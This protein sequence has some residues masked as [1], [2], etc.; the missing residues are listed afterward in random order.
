VALLFGCTGPAENPVE[1][2]W[3]SFVTEAY[4]YLTHQQ[5]LAKQDF[6]LGSWERYFWD[7]DA[8]TLTFSSNG[9]A[10][11]VAD[12][13]IVGSI[14]E[15]SGTWLWSWANSSILESMSSSIR[16]V[17]SLGEERGFEKLTEANWPG[18]E[19]DG[20]EMT[21]VAA[22]LLSAKGAYRAPDEDGALFLI[23]TDIH[24]VE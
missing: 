16:R 5:D 2:E 4:Q 15:I 14:S 9:R 17:R 21:A 22:L 19:T 20:W 7:Q 8:G 24:R 12:I 13:L 1:H 3:A 11:V 18:D 6:D 23:F 10:G